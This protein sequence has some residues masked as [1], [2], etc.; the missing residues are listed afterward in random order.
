MKRMKPERFEAALAL[1]AE[2]GS[3]TAPDL[4]DLM[5]IGRTSMNYYVKTLHEEKR[6]YVSAWRGF[7]RLGSP[8][9][10]WSIGE[11]PDVPMPI[12]G[13]PIVFR[14]K[15]SEAERWEKIMDARDKALRDRLAQQIRPWRDPMLFMTAG[16]AA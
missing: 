9:R 12:E 13:A 16:R 10:I 4:A 8:V 3:I 6:I 15:M 1:I 2:H 7:G 14:E 5:E 11:G